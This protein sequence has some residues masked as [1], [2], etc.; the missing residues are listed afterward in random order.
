MNN[1]LIK[2]RLALRQRAFGS[3]LRVTLG[4]KLIARTDASAQK[5]KAA[6][7]DF[8]ARNVFARWRFGLQFAPR[9]VH[10]KRLH[11]GATRRGCTFDLRLQFGGKFES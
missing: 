3:P 2:S 11:I 7:D 10:Q 8:L 6:F 1:A 5:T 4:Q 9:R